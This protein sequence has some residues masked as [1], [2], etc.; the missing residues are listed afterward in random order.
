MS[1]SAG[2]MRSRAEQTQLFLAACLPHL[3]DESPTILDWIE[4]GKTRRSGSALFDMIKLRGIEGLAAL[5][6]LTREQRLEALAQ[7]PEKSE[8]TVVALVERL[9]DADDPDSPAAALINSFPVSAKAGLDL[10]PAPTTTIPPA[11]MARKIEAQ[12][13]KDH[14][15]DRPA[16]HPAFRKYYDDLIVGGDEKGGYYSLLVACELARRMLDTAGDSDERGEAGNC[17]GYALWQLGERESGAERLEQAVS[18]FR[19]A[20][21]EYPRERVPL[22][23]A[24]IQNN[25]GLVLWRLG[26]REDGSARF[27]EA[28]RA[29]RAALEELTQERMPLD[30]AMTQNNLGIVLA[31]LG[32][33]EGDTERLAEAV[34]A[35]RAALEEWT[36]ERVPLD[37]AMTQNNLG[38]V[39]MR[40][41]QRESD[42]ERLAEAVSAYR[43]ALEEWTLK[44]TPRNWAMAQDNLSN[45]LVLLG[46]LE[47]KPE[48]FTEALQALRGAWE[49][50]RTLGYERLRES[51]EHRIAALEA[52][53]AG[54]PER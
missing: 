13:A 2:A 47:N 31:Q 28:E 15:T 50:F 26:E 16:W 14:A 54:R 37:W 36:R 53:I 19:A 40:L 43:A 29:F 45:A 48:L 34:N 6:P 25:L 49:V 21:E 1:A 4:R 24:A 38:N 17:L 41:G 10:V 27:I 39:L 9:G 32:E 23:W 30:W 35:F 12:V 8:D 22:K 3:V 52:L 42:T 5:A 18:A 20:L 7:L 46:A 11:E 33:R 44:R 51:F